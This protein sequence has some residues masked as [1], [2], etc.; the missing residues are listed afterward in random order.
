[1]EIIE[2]AFVDKFGA[3]YESGGLIIGSQRFP[4]NHQVKYWQ[5]VNLEVNLSKNFNDDTSHYKC[6]VPDVKIIPEAIY[7]GR[8]PTHFGHFLLEGIPRL[9]EASIMD[10]PVIGYIFSDKCKSKYCKQA[11]KNVKWLFNTIIK[12]KKY[13]IKKNAVYQVKKLYVPQ[14]PI[15]LSQSAAEPWKLE[16]TINKIV[17]AA[18]EEH[19]DMK[20]IKKLYL[21]RVGEK[22]KKKFLYTIS[23]PTNDVSKQIAMVS[24]AENLYGLVGT[25]THLS[26]FAQATATTNW[27]RRGLFI[28]RIRNQTICDLVKTYNNFL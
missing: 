10:K 14:Q 28:E 5:Q 4:S 19:L 11:R 21:K 9:A 22:I 1:M 8:L 13:K 7:V 25:N 12:Q 15:I 23:S 2:N 16:S 24:C 20:K 27:K 6:D 3:Y 17:M 18:R 26:I